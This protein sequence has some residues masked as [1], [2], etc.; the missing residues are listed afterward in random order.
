MTMKRLHKS[1]VAGLFVFSFLPLAFGFCCCLNDTLAGFFSASKDNKSS[2]EDHCSGHKQSHPTPKQCEHD[3]LSA[4]TA[5]EI[6]II[7]TALPSIAGFTSHHAG[8]FVS[9]TKTNFKTNFFDTGPP[10]TISSTP[11]YL[12]ISVLRI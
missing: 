9:L 1:W 5:N 12:R 6:L 4:K 8:E 3:Q 10:H 2:Y 11:L 7:T